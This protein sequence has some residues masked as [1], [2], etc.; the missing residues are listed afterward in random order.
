MNIRGFTSFTCVQL[1]ITSILCPFFNNYVCVSPETFS[2]AVLGT[3]E[4]PI[5]PY[6]FNNPLFFRIHVLFRI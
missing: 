4:K 1:F 3:L 6:N 2:V 5:I